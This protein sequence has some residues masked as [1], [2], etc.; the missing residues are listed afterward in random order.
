M[1]TH[2]T[3]LISDK[4]WNS[5]TARHLLNRAGFGVPFD[6]IKQLQDYG[7]RKAVN[8]MVNCDKFADDF[9]EPDWL[10]EQK[11]GKQI[12]EEFKSLEEDE[13]R[14]RRQQM[15]KQNRQAIQKLKTWWI[16]RSM[17]TKRPLQ[18]K[19]AQFWHGHFATSAQKVNNAMQ[20]Y[21]I[22]QIFR[23]HALGNFKTLVIKVS[24]APAMLQYLDNRRNVKKHPNENF[25]RELMELF[26]IGIGHYS[27]KDIQEAAR[28]FTGWSI[29]EGKFFDRKKQHDKGE[30][31]FLGRRGKFNGYDIIGILCNQPIMT[32]FICKKLW[33]FFV[34]ENPDEKL[35]KQLAKVFRSNNLELKPVLKMVF[36]SKE[37]YSKR[38]M[39]QQIKS[40]VQFMISM[41]D[42]LQ[43]ETKESQDRLILLAM[44]QMG[45][46]LFY[47]PNVKGWPGNRAWINS[48]TLLTR[49]NIPAF[50]LYGENTI[51][52]NRRKK[53]K[54]KKVKIKNAP[55]NAEPFF[56][57]YEGLTAEQTIDDLSDRF[58]G[59]SLDQKQKQVLLEA[60]H[61]N[62]HQKLILPGA[63][64]SSER[65]IGVVH[66]ILS[67]AEYQLC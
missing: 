32:E 7:P 10:P 66:L 34:Y 19:M 15:R 4:E 59:R 28:A 62:A 60:I 25:A 35:V 57:K 56:E 2:I 39:H 61:S 64:E 6:H 44:Q 67:T 51:K 16:K 37:F 46:D 13:K 8:F 31:E 3:K 54:K 20:N 58:I 26:T 38:S 21:E 14:K 43:V 42:Q 11:T 49:Y 40:P 65:L 47:P 1:S 23:E 17:Q 48:N 45:Q 5:E 18:E 50:L 36:N 63:K 41:L 33:E 55:F 29:R 22:N 27:E 30:K 53:Q 24:Q 9:P 52:Q 12:R